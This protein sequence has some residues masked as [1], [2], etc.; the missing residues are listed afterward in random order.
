MYWFTKIGPDLHFTREYLKAGVLVSLLSVWVLVALFYYLNRY[1]KRRYFSIWTVAWLFYALWMSLSFGFQAAGEPIQLMLQQWSIGIS[2]VFLLWGSLAFLGHP[3]RQSSLAWFMVF[4]LVWSYIGAYHLKRPLEMQIPI[5]WLIA[6]A[7]FFTAYSFFK[8]RRKQPYVGA[9]LLT[10]GFFLWGFYM[11]AYPFLERAEN[12]TSLALFSS[13]VLQLTLAVSMII[14]VLEEARH[15]LQIIVSQ[16]QTRMEERD[17]LASRVI[18][19][20]ERYQ[21]LFDQA[22]E[23]IVITSVD[24]FRILE[25]NQAGERLL[26]IQRNEADQHYLITFCHVKD[27]SSAIPQNS[28]EWFQ[29]LCRQRPL[30][31]VRKNGGIVSLE[32]NVS[33]ISLDG[34]PAYQFFL[35]ELTERAR[36]EQQLRQAEKLSALGQMISGVAHELNNPL[37]VVKGYLELVLA[38]H[39]VNP[40]T[41][42]DLEKAAHESNRAAKLVT[43]FLSFAREQP[44]HREL[45]VFNELISRLVDFWKLDA[46]MAKTEMILE[47]D[48][49]LPP[50]LADPDQIQQLLVNLL[51]N[52][53]QA[54]A[55]ISGPAR[56]KLQTRRVGEK[57]QIAVEDSGP[58]VPLHLA[59]KIFEPFFTTK[60]VGT[61][62][63]LGLSIAHSIMTEHQG[64]IF[65]QAAS[66]GGAGFVLEFTAS[67]P[68]PRERVSSG[69]TAMFTRANAILKSCKGNILV[70]DDEKSL[71]EM[72]SEMLDLLGYTITTCHVATDALELIET[73]DFDLVVSDFRM[74]GINGQQFYTMAV[75]IKPEL[76]RRII[77]VTGD[78]VNTETKA[79]LESTGNPH[80]AKPFNLSNVSR[81][82]AEVIEKNREEVALPN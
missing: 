13:A 14:L 3:V 36:L 41:R 10:I 53:V 21:K 4:L 45:I 77:F 75:H 40:Q 80:L 63:G 60:E 39:E 11:A 66:L 20:E 51:N 57:V 71:A 49:E 64:R 81:A 70:L 65:Y 28:G 76:A 67:Q 42:A 35:I 27:S 26:G 19:T 8:Y 74:P 50:V 61:G 54:M 82:V 73:Q 18:S 33:Q 31:L 5:L 68:N 15:T 62:T 17:A 6:I 12:W 79:F 56:L 46:S 29:F 2:A 48:P 69:D 59:T 32:V 52:A 43:N 24:D 47:L 30:N 78:V 22:G 58:G 1:T 9:T 44:A 7:S 23:A 16:A 25:I 55:D 37:A 34:T 72:L 38:H